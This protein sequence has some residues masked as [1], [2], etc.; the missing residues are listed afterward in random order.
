MLTSIVIVKA[1]ASG[2][3]KDID[4]WKKFDESRIIPACIMFNPN[5]EDVEM[6]RK[7]YHAGKPG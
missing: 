3:F 1:V 4:V 7:R 6:L 5:P 2:P